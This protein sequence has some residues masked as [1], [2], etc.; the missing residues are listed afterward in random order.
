V[1]RGEQAKG[2]WAQSS[3]SEETGARNLEVRPGHIR[4][5]LVSHSF[6]NNPELQ[7]FSLPTR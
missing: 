7:T 2:E 6:L 1:R 5:A 4:M 3:R